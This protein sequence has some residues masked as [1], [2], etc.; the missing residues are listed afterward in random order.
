MMMAKRQFHFTS[1]G[2]NLSL[3]FRDMYSAKFDSS[4][5]GPQPGA[6]HLKPRRL[7]GKNVKWGTIQRSY[8]DSMI[9]DQGNS[10]DVWLF[11][12]TSMKRPII[13]AH[14]Q[15]G[16]Y[17]FSC[18]QAVLIMVIYVHL[19]VTQFS[20]LSCRLIIMNFSGVITS[21]CNSVNKGVGPHTVNLIS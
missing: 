15:S 6:I 19:S 5:H 2:E 3:G 9:L 8:D 18:D 17:I 16:K 21:V 12:F 14:N 1:N 11:Y 13:Y 7:C 20:Q 10:E 4:P